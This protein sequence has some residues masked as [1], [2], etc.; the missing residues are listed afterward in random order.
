M[1]GKH[2]GITD[3]LDSGFLTD[4]DAGRDGIRDMS[5]EG[6]LTS[7]HFEVATVVPLAC[8]DHAG[9]GQG[10]GPPSVP[11]FPHSL[12]ALLRWLGNRYLQLRPA[13]STAAQGVT[14]ANRITDIAALA[15]VEMGNRDIET[16]IQQ[17]DEAYFQFFAA[18]LEKS[19]NRQAISER[20]SSA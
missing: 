10:R 6:A 19:K 15:K 4:T 3:R 11:K 20:G 18:P 1:A 7:D 14:A 12:V 5:G 16:G 13:L 17:A 9:G 8:L 2:K